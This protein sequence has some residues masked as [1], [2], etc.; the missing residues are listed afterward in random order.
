MTTTE[1]LK[2]IVA[3][4]LAN[5]GATIDTVT[6]ERPTAGWLVALP[7]NENI[8]STELF[9]I[10]AVQ[11]YLDKYA[12][13]LNRVG[14]YLGTWVDGG[15]VYLDTSTLINRDDIAERLGRQYRQ[16]AIFNIG[17]GE[18]RSLAEGSDAS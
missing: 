12:D 18:T 1:S 16:L 7:S 17:T 9:D 10:G 4:T 3:D 5:G 13:D 2:T 14:N 8:V 6:G 11:V 15:K